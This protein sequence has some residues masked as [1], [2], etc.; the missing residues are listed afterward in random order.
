MSAIPEHDPDKI[1]CVAKSIEK[2]ITFS[3]D[4]IQFLDS[5]NFLPS[6]LESLV[7]NL[8]QKGIENFKILSRFFPE[9]KLE[10]LTR[11]QVFP[12][13]WFDDYKKLDETSLPPIEAFYND[14]N[15]TP[16]TLEDYEHAKKVWEVFDMKTFRDYHNLY[17]TIDV[18]LLAD[19]FKAFRQFCLE[20]YKLLVDP[21]HYYTTPSLTWDAML[22]YTKVKLEL[23]T[24][25]DQHL[26]V[27]NGIRGGMCMVGENRYC[28]AN[29]PEVPGYNENEPTTWLSYQDVNNLYGKSESET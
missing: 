13:S 12:Y 5:Y 8:K 16:C 10:L 22:K 7:D 18:L 2:Y 4:D 27:E 6:S 21:V 26:M 3:L 19:V 28:R 9:D 14:L 1:V 15:D 17:V 23:L 25:L 20:T 11:K 29:N 24:D